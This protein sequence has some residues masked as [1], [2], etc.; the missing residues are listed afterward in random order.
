ME[1]TESQNHG[2]TESRNHRITE[3][4]KASGKAGSQERP[5]PY[6]YIY[7]YIYISVRCEEMGTKD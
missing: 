3:P 6:I 7:I 2:I 5:L 4:E 1:L